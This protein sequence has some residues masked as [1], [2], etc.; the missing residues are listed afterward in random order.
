MHKYQDIGSENLYITETDS[1]APILQFADF[2]V[3]DTSS[4]ITEF[5][6]L[7]KSNSIIITLNDKAPEDHLLNIIK[8]RLK[9]RLPKR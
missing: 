5:G 1:L 4:M 7:S 8:T 6:L 3:S 9:K 2:I